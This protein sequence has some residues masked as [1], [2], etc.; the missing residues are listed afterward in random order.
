MKTVRLT[1]KL[2]LNHQNNPDLDIEVTPS[3][4]DSIYIQG[5]IID[6]SYL[7]DRI[8]QL[9]TLDEIVENMAMILSGKSKHYDFGDE[10][11]VFYCEQKYTTFSLMGKKICRLYTNE[12]YNLFVEWK[13]FFRKYHRDGVLYPLSVEE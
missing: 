2:L 3:V 4:E 11:G 5:S 9:L 10:E 12:V 7:I 13:T 8:T 1:Y 6:I